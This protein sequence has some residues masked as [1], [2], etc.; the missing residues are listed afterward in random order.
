MKSCPLWITLYCF[1]T[2]KG[3]AAQIKLEEQ[4][5]GKLYAICHID[6]Y[7]GP[8]VQAVADSS[9]YITPCSTLQQSTQ[10]HTGVD[11]CTVGSSTIKQS[12]QNRTGHN[13]QESTM[14]NSIVNNSTVWYSSVRYSTEQYSTVQY[15]TVQYSTV[16]Y[17]TVQYSTVV[18]KKFKSPAVYEFR[19]CFKDQKT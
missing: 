19:E 13:R 18:V 17:S 1:Q 8:A 14:H 16:Q 3:K 5:S 10:Q 4:G 2:C 7:P 6:T 9:R 15:S 11:C 12:T